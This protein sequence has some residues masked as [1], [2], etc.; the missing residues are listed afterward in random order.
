MTALTAIVVA[1][2]ADDIHRTAFRM[3]TKFA[4][5]L[6]DIGE[7]QLAGAPQSVLQHRHKLALY[8]PVVTSGQ[9]AKIVG[10]IL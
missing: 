6:S 9:C 7:R 10:E 5:P 3:D 2:F 4:H 8:G 1:N